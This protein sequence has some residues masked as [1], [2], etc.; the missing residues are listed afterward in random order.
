MV[1]VQALASDKGPAF[2]CLELARNGRLELCVS[3]AVLLE[4]RDVMNR[5]RLRKKLPALTRERVDAFLDHIVSYATFATHA[6]LPGI[7]STELIASHSS[8]V[9]CRSRR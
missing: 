4:V 2:A 8:W 7:W 6:P 1:F 9:D 5:P 3:P